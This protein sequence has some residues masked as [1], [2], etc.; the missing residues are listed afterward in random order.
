M[1]GVIGFHALRTRRSGSQKFIEF[2]LEVERSKKFEE[3]HEI[4]VNVIRAIEDE[5]PR[6]RVQIHTDPWG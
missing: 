6:A 2:H 4:T 5:I 1:Q 3:A